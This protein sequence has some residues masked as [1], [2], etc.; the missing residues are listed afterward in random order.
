MAYTTAR[1]SAEANALAVALRRSSAKP[2]RYWETAKISKSEA[3]RL[4]RSK[5]D[6]L[7]L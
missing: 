4:C 2:L 1:I 3:H 6:K 7:G 5:K